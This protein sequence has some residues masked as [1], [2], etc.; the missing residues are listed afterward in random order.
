MLS[1]DYSIILTISAVTAFDPCLA[2]PLTL[3]PSLFCYIDFVYTHGG[4]LIIERI[5]NETVF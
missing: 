5:L 1:L 3:L 4:D 2:L